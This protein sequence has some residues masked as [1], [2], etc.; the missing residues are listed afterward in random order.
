MD[1]NQK[2]LISEFLKDEKLKGRMEKGLK[3][4]KQTVPKFISWLDLSDLQFSEV[5]V[6]EALSYQE[7]LIETG[8]LDGDKYHPSTVRNFL[9]G[10]INF[11]EFLK[12]RG[13]VHDNPFRQIRKIREEKILPRNILKEKQM[14]ALLSKLSLFDSEKGLK[15]QI[16][17]Y[18]VHVIAELM[19]ASGLRI[20]EVADLATSDIDFSKGIINVREGKGGVPR[21]A[22]LGDYSKEILNLY[23]TGMRKLTFSWWHE[24]NNHLLFGTPWFS[25]EKL[26]NKTL[27]KVSGNLKIGHFTSHGFRHALGYHLL[28]SGCNIRYIQEILGHKHLKNTE[29]YTKVDRED[30]RD[31]LDSFHPRKFREE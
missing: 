5:G 15:N 22:W 13:L 20:G 29:I 18:K 27:K 26:V 24:R 6:K 28:R 1:N 3:T 25:L 23:I 8:R 30:L 9:K 16:T 12:D 14:D 2:E 11:Y 31:V 7:W 19:Y 4:L 10:A 17:M 21:V